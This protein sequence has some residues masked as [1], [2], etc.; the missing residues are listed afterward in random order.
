[1]E[2]QDWATGPPAAG[3]SGA[4]GRGSLGLRA[5]GPL[6]RGPAFSK[7]PILSADRRIAAFVDK[8]EAGLKLHFYY[9]D[10]LRIFQ[11]V[12]PG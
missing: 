11:P 6:G 7:T 4:V 12:C 3:L 9:M 8:K 2:N 1:M 10:F 5:F